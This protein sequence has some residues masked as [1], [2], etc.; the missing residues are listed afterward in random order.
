MKKEWSF[1]FIMIFVIIMISII[2]FGVYLIVNLFSKDKEFLLVT[3]PLYILK[4]EKWDCENVT[5]KLGG[6]NNKKYNI[7]FD[8]NNM[9]V[10][11][12]YFNDARK[13]FYIFDDSDNNILKEEKFIAYSGS[14][15]VQK[16]FMEEEIT[17]REYK[18]LKDKVNLDYEMEDVKRVS[19]DFD[20]DGEKENIYTINY[21]M[22]EEYYALFN[23]LLYED[24][25]KLYVIDRRVTEKSDAG[26]VYIS[27]VLDIFDD[28][29]IEFIYNTEY[30]DNIGYCSQIYR[31]KG[32]KFVKVNDCDI[33][34][35][36]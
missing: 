10:N 19:Y 7:Y 22:N 31:L 28:G 8:G 15:I 26:Y 33:V 13:K 25:G 30:F 9:G 18:K 36:A 23:A 27:N 17:S 4:C 24:D 3:D 20:N 14:K 21:P 29:K 2:L 11:T 32:K 5:N 16:Y 12:L 35:N 1:E 34:K 6:L